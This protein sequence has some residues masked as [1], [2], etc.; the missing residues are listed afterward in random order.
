MFIR[1]RLLS[2][3]VALWKN[4]ELLQKIDRMPYEM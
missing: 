4:N 1:Y 2:K 3:L